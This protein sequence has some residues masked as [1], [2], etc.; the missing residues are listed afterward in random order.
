MTKEAAVL[1][2]LRESQKLSMRRAALITNLSEAKINHAENGRCDLMPSLT[3]KILNG[4]G[5]CYEK[6]VELVKGNCA[7]PANDYAE[8]IEILKRLDKEK[9]RTVKTILES[10]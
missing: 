1:K 4:Y 8:C 10:F 7:M 5:Y 6:F 9:L 2:Y 3:L